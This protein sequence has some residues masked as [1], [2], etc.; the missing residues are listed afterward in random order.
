M[1]SDTFPGTMKEI[2]GGNCVGGGSVREE[3]RG[4][5]VWGTK[6]QFLLWAAEQVSK[7]SY[8]RTPGEEDCVREL[9]P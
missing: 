3:R 8:Y 1:V 9:F 4:D 6:Y 5:G 7:L 2:V